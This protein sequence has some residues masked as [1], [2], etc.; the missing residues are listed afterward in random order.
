[1]SRFESDVARKD[2]PFAFIHAQDREIAKKT[3]WPALEI[4]SIGRVGAKKK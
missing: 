2:E 4:K 3:G 1:L